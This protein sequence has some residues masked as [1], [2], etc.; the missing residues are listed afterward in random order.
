M[1][2]RIFYVLGGPSQP[3]LE[4]NKQ[5]GHQPLSE[6]NVFVERNDVQLVT[7]DQVE[8]GHELSLRRRFVLANW[9]RRRSSEYDLLIASGEDIGIPV[10]LAS[11]LMKTPK[12]VWII[13]HGSYLRGKKFAAIA[14]LL[15]RA[16]HV[17]FLCLAESLRTM[18]VEQY[19]FPSER[20]HNAGYGVDTSF[21]QP[22]AGDRAALVVSA[23]SANRDYPTLISAVEGLGVPLRIAADSLWRPTK[24]AVE[25]DNLPKFVT[26]GSAGNYLGL[27]SLYSEAS[28]IVVPLHPARYACGYAVIA[29]AMAMGKVVITTRTEAPSDLIVDGV[30][31][32]QVEPGDVLGLRNVI[33]SLLE[34]PQKASAMGALAA[35]RIQQEFSLPAYCARIEQFISGSHDAV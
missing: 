3:K 8:G 22:E 9:L 27:R 20:C 16:R 28:I 30:T 14:P 7:T 18:M 23:G 5:L 33:R 25:Q 31:G 6:F 15:R 29:E 24:S 21:F 17:H 10:A 19:G 35:A 2:R 32:F 4:T 1:R 34:D 26:F 11:L 13:L 12:P